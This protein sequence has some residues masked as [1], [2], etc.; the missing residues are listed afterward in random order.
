M[1]K[2][3]KQVL[4]KDIVATL[5]SYP[6]L[7]LIAN[8]KLNGKFTIKDNEGVIQGEFDI[9]IIIPSKYPNEFPK[10]YELSKK[11]PR[12]IDR[13]IDKNGLACVEIEQNISIESKKGIT[14]KHFIEKYVHR[15]F[16]WQ[17]RYDA[18]DFEGLEEW[19]HYDK[20]TIQFYKEK[21]ALDD[22]NIIALILKSL[23]ENTLPGRNEMCLC[24]SGIKYK[25]CHE[26]LVDEIQTLGKMQFEKD[27]KVILDTLKN[28]HVILP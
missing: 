23:I 18:K 13:H 15:Y 25:L 2:T 28:I 21:L 14:I 4:D 16:C 8:N 9:G 27:L 10:L 20:G 26:R 19:A 24:P 3:I 7:Q 22:L 17:L 5:E 1:A 12:D 11:I 6:E